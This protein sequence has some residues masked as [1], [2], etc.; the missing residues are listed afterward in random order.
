MTNLR[1]NL[2]LIEVVYQNQGKKAVM[3]FLDI[4]NGE[5]LEVNFN[6]QIWA[7]GK[8]VDDKEKEENVD[9]WCEEYF[10]KDFDSLSERVGDRFDV[11]KYPKFNSMWEAEEINKFTKD[12]KGMIFNSTIESVKDTGTRISITYKIDDDLFETKM[13]YAEYVESLNQWFPNPQKKERQYEKFED[14]F[15]VSVEK[16]DEIIGKEIMVEVNVAFG[17]YAYGDIKKPQWA[18]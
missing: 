11:Y 18:K 2:E 10:N 13:Q 4:E 16:A 6:K 3:K 1:K 17:K 12:Q 8:Y 7:N 14:K 5:L 9:K 15:G